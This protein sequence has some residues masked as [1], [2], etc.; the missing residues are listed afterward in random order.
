MSAFDQAF[1]RSIAR[2]RLPYADFTGTT[3]ATLNTQTLFTHGLQNQT[4]TAV[5]P[6]RVMLTIN[7]TSAPAGHLYEAATNHTTTQ[8]D[9]RATGASVVFRARAWI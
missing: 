3:N 8:C 4:G 5:A 6:S 9:I 2:S 7:M 1:T